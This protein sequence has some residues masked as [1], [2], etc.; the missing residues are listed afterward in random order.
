MRELARKQ[1]GSCFQS[2]GKARRVVDMSQHYLAKILTRHSFAMAEKCVMHICRL[3]CSS[4]SCCECQLIEMQN[5]HFSSSFESN[6]LKL[7]IHC[8]SMLI[9]LIPFVLAAA[10]SHESAVNPIRF[11]NVKT[12]DLLKSP[13]VEILPNSEEEQSLAQLSVTN[14]NVLRLPLIGE[15][16]KC[17]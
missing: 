8:T 2:L 5:L 10:Q 11:Y 1:F 12:R 6:Q 13:I 15:P 4:G 14:T 9:V 3:M 7:S 16:C 17:S